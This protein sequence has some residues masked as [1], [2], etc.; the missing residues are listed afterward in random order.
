MKRLIPS[1]LVTVITASAALADTYSVSPADAWAQ[2]GSKLVFDSASDGTLGSTTTTQS[3]STSAG[4]S[5]AIS[6]EK[7]GSGT[8]TVDGVHSFTGDIDIREGMLAVGNGAHDKPNPRNSALGDP[9]STR[10]IVIY[11]NATLSISK[12]GLFGNAKT[13]TADILADL[14]VRGGTLAVA[15]GM[16]EE[17]GNVL[18][19]DATANIGSGTGN[20]PGFA[21]SGDWLE[22]GSSTATPFTLT[23][24]RGVRF[25]KR[26]PVEIRVPDI[27]GDDSSDV[28]FSAYLN[29]AD[30]TNWDN[31]TNY[32]KT[33]VGTLEFH[34]KDSTFRRDAV[35]AEGTLKL[36]AGNARI[37]NAAS[38]LGSTVVSHTII[39]ESG[40]TLNL[41]ASDLFGQGYNDPTGVCIHIKGG[42]LVQDD[43]F[44]NAFGPLVL[45]D[46]T[47]VHGQGAYASS[48]TPRWPA[49]AFSEVT[50]CGTTAYDLAN[51]ASY[52]VFG[53]NGMR[54]LRVEKIVSDGTYS[55]AT[56][57]VTISQ[58]IRDGLNT[59]TGGGVTYGPRATTFRK[60]GPGVLRLANTGNDFTGDLEIAEGIVTLGKKGTN[61]GYG[62]TSSALGNLMTNRTVTVCG[63]GELYYSDSDQLGQACADIEASF[64]VSNGTVRFKSG[65]VNGWPAVKFYD[66]NLVYGN[67]V[68]S[69]G[70]GESDA[71]G[72]WAFRYPVAFDGT[73]AL[74]LPA[75]GTNNRI[76]LGY[77]SDSSEVVDGGLT[78]CHGRT[79]LRVED[80][81]RDACVDVD[82]GMDVQSLPYWASGNN[83]ARP[84]H[85]YRCGL[86][87]TG[88]G[89]L[90]LGGRFTC[91]ESTKVDGGSLLF[92]GVLAEQQSGWGLSAFEIG[93]GA[94]L[95]GTGTVWNVT[96]EEGGG[97]TSAVGQTGALAIAGALTLPASGNVAI[98]VVCTNDLSTM[99]GSISVPVVRSSGLENATFRPV[100]NGGQPLPSLF[101]LT[102]KV[103][104]GFVWGQLSKNEAT[105]LIVR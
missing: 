80:M 57:D 43:K 33:G 84:N 62:A 81:T 99:T 55:A 85:R 10:K 98:N 5:G 8:L 78:Y 61:N 47:L 94:F 74:S 11:T 69:S 93:D 100:F 96:V 105:T 32:I 23:S 79:E 53:M 73:K 77:S 24:S 39:V 68:G 13:S 30:G 48:S 51:T 89:T 19:F 9:S 66:A 67:G 54:D 16:G 45:E 2:E 29:D 21:V 41:A 35:V 7:K 87:K 86:K 65:T 76:S 72:L 36:T 17:F 49:F 90:R 83:K 28:I 71:W 50:F 56:P 70:T 91:P 18:F 25:G 102:T 37:G 27:T 82:I 42:S 97:F 103:A 59:W 14:E 92:D 101:T 6:L 88:P 75:R 4:L 20:W 12:P 95:G 15:D 63:E 34:N 64:V 40:A 60:V 31:P 52:A 1:L 44:S 46:A 104:D 26:K 58:Q 38:A 22:F 3:T